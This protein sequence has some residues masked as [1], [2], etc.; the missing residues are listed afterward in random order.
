MARRCQISGKQTASGNNISH[1]HVKTRRKFKV[2]LVSKR[3]YLPDEN[4]WVRLRISARM[5]KTLNKKGVKSLM[6]KY[7]QDL[8]QLQA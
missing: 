8:R 6:K 1:S 5:L 3:V 4:R 7:G 2:N